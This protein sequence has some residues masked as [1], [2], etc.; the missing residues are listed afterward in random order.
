VKQSAKDDSAVQPAASRGNSQIVSN[1]GPQVL[2][3]AGII[4]RYFVGKGNN[5]IMVRSLFKNR[6]WWVQHDK[7]D[8]VGCNFCWTQLSAPLTRIGGNT[9]H[10]REDSLTTLIDR[11]RRRCSDKARR[12]CDRAH[13]SFNPAQQRAWLIHIN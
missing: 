11:T 1:T 2:P 4:Y 3:P 13:L 9:K 7:E 6:F 10:T 12:F 8:I 5:S